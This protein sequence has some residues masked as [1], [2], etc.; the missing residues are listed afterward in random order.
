M[1]AACRTYV[2]TLFLSIPPLLL[3]ASVQ[4]APVWGEKST[5]RQPDGEMVE[6]RIWGDEFYEVVESLD[7]YTLIRHPGNGKICYARLSPDKNEFVSTGIRVAKTKPAGVALAK[8][9]RIR[10][11][12]RRAKVRVARKHFAE[13]ET[14]ALSALPL[15]SSQEPHPLSTTEIEGICL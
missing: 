7:G 12:S 11:E 6:V 10:P 14:P 5:R 1:T 8:H 13:I 4:A 15:S 3:A 9:L 2:Y